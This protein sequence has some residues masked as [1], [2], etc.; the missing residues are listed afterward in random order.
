M[1][2]AFGVL[3]NLPEGRVT[4]TPE[5]ARQ[6]LADILGHKRPGGA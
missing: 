4:D 2:E 3:K 1:L 6:Q 5:R